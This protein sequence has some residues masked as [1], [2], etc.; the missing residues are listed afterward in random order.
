MGDAQAPDFDF[1]LARSTRR[2]IVF[3]ECTDRE[4][5]CFAERFRLDDFRALVSLGVTNY[6][7]TVDFYLQ[8]LEHCRSL[9]TQHG[10]GLRVL[11]RALW[12]WSKAR[13]TVKAP[14]LSSE[15]PDE[16]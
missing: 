15:G 11:D 10:V 13:G 6:G 12:Q 16:S 2:A 3:A 4:H 7:A 1:Q 8:Y 14:R 5:H 9:A